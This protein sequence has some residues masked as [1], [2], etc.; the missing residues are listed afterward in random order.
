MMKNIFWINF[1]LIFLVT[2]SFLQ[3]KNHFLAH[4]NLEPYKNERYDFSLL[5]TK[6]FKKTF[7]KNG[8]GI[9]LVSPISPEI[10]IRAWGSHNALFHKMEEHIDFI[11]QSEVIE[12]ISNIMF[13]SIQWKQ[14][15]SKKRGMKIMR[16]I[17]LKN[18]I[19]YSVYCSAPIKEFDNYFSL[20]E[21][22]SHSF[23]LDFN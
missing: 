20:F 5:I 3:S 11:A 4:E 15:I 7:S 1:L 19:F 21:K 22:V 10:E 17:S 9:K 6:S 14:I 16:I 2:I 23:R 12:S 18:D 13:N 8:D